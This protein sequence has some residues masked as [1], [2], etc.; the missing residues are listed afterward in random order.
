M[1]LK[2][3]FGT[4]L[5]LFTLFTITA[6]DE[7]LSIAEE[8]PRFPGCEVEPKTIIEKCA[9]AKMF[10]FIRRN[11]RY[12]KDAYDAGISGRSIVQ[13]VVNKDGSLSDFKL[14]RPENPSFDKEALR[15]VKAMPYWRPGKQRGKTVRVRITL[16]IK[17]QYTVIREQFSN[18]GDL[19]CEKYMAEIISTE[20][21]RALAKVPF[22]NKNI[23]SIDGMSAQLVSITMTHTVGEKETIL[24]STDGA[25]TNAMNNTLANIK[26]GESISFDYKIAYEIIEG[27]PF[28]QEEYRAIV[29]K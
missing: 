21:L 16:P 7:V 10:G 9:Q 15:I 1:N 6:Q 2:S 18:I 20:K 26:I 3:L 19:F 5:L 11:I 28:T 13:F 25:W 22:E 24:K 17:F 27:K 8:M 29:A 4:F 12:P 23:C 14:P